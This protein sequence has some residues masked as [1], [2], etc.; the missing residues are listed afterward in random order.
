MA[1]AAAASANEAMAVDDE[2][3]VILKV[4]LKIFNYSGVE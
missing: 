4:W 2:V 1:A 3:I